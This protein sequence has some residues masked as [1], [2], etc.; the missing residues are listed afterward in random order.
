[1]GLQLLAVA[2]IVLCGR[3]ILRKYGPD[4]QSLPEESWPPISVIVPATGSDPAMA[5]SIR[6]LVNQD[7]PAFELLFVTRCMDDPAAD[8]IRQEIRGHAFARHVCS[9]MAIACGQKNHNL[10]AGVREADGASRILVFCDSGRLAPPTWLKTLVAPMVLQQVELTTAYH[11]VI[12][13]DRTLAA[14]GR[15]VTVLGMYLAIS[16]PWLTAPW[17]GATAFQ[18]SVF[19]KLRVEELW[20]DNVVDDISLAKPL[21]EAGIRTFLVPAA[22]LPTL[23]RDET[24][25]GWSGWVTRQLLFL[26]FCLPLT[27]IATGLLLYS[28][29]V[30]PVLGVIHC[31]AWFLGLISAA[32]AVLSL[33]FLVATGGLGAYLRTFH[34]AP[35]PLWRWLISVYFTPMV[36]AWSHVTTM[37]VR[38]INWRRNTYRVTWKGRI[39][40]IREN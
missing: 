12:P 18:R 38:E 22:C 30:L 20:A 3:R 32:D 24:M 34:P 40:E 31:I 2:Y 39:K 27:W 6:S 35:G 36:C 14:V 1:M 25:S 17:G 7:Y 5:S 37:L 29:A 23:L 9:G 33:A 26:K 21:R 10:L 13:Q 11:H 4:H 16:V 15:A 28:L 8:I 19:R